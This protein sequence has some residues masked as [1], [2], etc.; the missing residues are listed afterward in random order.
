MGNW[1][2]KDFHLKD[3]KVFSAERKETW[4]GPNYPMHVVLVDIR[5]DNR[6]RE[7]LKLT[8]VFLK[9]YV[10]QAPIRT[11]MWSERE[12]SFTSL[13]EIKF[14]NRRNFNILPKNEEGHFEIRVNIPPYIDITEIIHIYIYGYVTLISSFGSFDKPVVV[15][16]HVR[17]EEWR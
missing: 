13:E 10:N 11:I 14:T 12:K 8:S 3:A 9:L 4:G 7:D 1:G 17:P 5:W 16:L 2:A 6:S 15:S